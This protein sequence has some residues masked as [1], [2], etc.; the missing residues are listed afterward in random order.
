[1][2]LPER[3]AIQHAEPHVRGYR[4]VRGARAGC[5]LER[6]LYRYSGILRVRV[7]TRIHPRPHRPHLHGYEQSNRRVTQSREDALWRSKSYVRFFLFFIIINLSQISSRQQE[8][9]LLDQD[10]RRSMR[11][12]S[13]KIGVKVGMLLLGGCRLGKPLRALRPLHLR[14]HQRLRE[15]RRKRLR[16]RERVRVEQRHMQRWRHVRQ[17]RWILSLR[18]SPRIDFRRYA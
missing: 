5:V 13:A 6:N 2:Y 3:D 16:G 1:M 10:D 17:H 11:V 8:R 7:F 14:V 15:I 18:V 4:R 12:Q 9:L